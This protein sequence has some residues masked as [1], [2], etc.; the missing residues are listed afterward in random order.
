MRK[1]KFLVIH[2]T[3]TPPGRKVTG[4]DIR[5]W[6]TDPKPKG[7]GWSRV[8]YSD[9]IHLDGTIENLHEFDHDE[10]V[11]LDEITN[12][13][14]GFNGVSRHIC[15]VGGSSSNSKSFDSRTR[16]QKDTILTYCKH[17]IHRHPD[18]RIAGHNDLSNKGCPSFNVK[19]F[20]EANGIPKKNI[21]S[22]F[23]P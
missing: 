8:G 9:L 12:G 10:Y 7:R 14:Y 22:K 23:N 19:R 15:Y 18:I 17:M 21:F 4:N 20:L 16:E 13:A 2:C 3:D 1:L 11:D 5:R 6:H